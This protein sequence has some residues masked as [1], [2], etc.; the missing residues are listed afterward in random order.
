MARWVRKQ[1]MAVDVRTSR[2]LGVAIATGIHPVRIVV[3]A[4][5]DCDTELR[6]AAYVGVGRMIVGSSSQADFL[7]VCNEPR[8][9]GVLV[10]TTDPAARS[11]PEN[12]RDDTGTFGLPFATASTD[13][14]VEAVLAHRRLSLQ[15]LHCTVGWHHGGFFSSEAA[16]DHMVAE[17]SRIRRR[18]DIVLTRLSLR[19]EGPLL[20]SVVE[21]RTL[22]AQIDG[23]LDNACAT[24]RFP[25]PRVLVSFA[26]LVNA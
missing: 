18:H 5:D 19:R 8:T 1:S 26:P 4:A 6:C 24:M 15:G 10:R 21:L 3:D 2:Q 20:D 23:A 12:D 22:A 16:I 14:T 25:R 11:W 17:L 13:R 7:A 9:Q